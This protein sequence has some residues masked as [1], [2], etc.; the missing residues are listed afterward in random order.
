MRA[1]YAAQIT[2]RDAGVFEL[3]SDP[4]AALELIQQEIGRGEVVVLATSAAGPDEAPMRDDLLSDHVYEGGPAGDLIQPYDPRGTGYDPFPVDGDDLTD[5]FQA[6]LPAADGTGYYVATVPPG[7]A[8]DK[9]L[10][11]QPHFWCHGAFIG[12]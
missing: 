5:Y 12:T 1:T 10:A 4:D 8:A 2:G 11:Q 9:D 6:Q 3:P 7:V